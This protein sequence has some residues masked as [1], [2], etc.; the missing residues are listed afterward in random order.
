MTSAA[1]PARLLTAALLTGLT[2][3]VVARQRGWEPAGIAAQPPRLVPASRHDV[4]YAML[5]AARTGDVPRFL[6][7]F[8]GPLADSLKRSA[9]EQGEARFA[10]Y[11]RQSNEPIKGFAVADLPP[12]SDGEIKVRVELVYRDR[13]EAQIFHLAGQ[14]VAWRIVRLEAAERVRTLVPYGAPAR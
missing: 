10:Q 13:N 3:F 11:L 5:D 12:A 14:G 1:K 2:L 8:Q 6:S 4:I 9:D 7:C